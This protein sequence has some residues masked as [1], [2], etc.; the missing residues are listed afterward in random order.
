[1]C[2]PFFCLQP[3]SPTDNIDDIMWQVFCGWSY[4][5]G[6]VVLGTNPFTVS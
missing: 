4:A 5:V 1:M 6:D 3:N 2:K